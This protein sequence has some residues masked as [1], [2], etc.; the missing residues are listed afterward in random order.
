MDVGLEF[1]PTSAV[2]FVAAG[3]AVFLYASSHPELPRRWFGR[4]PLMLAVACA[5]LPMPFLVVFLFDVALARSHAAS[6]ASSS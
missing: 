4:R 1:R 2:L 3:V 5:V 6:R